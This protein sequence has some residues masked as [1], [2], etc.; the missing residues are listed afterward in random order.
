MQSHLI[1][2]TERGL[3]CSLS[4]LA[5][6]GT[7]GL[8]NAMNALRGIAVSAL[9]VATVL[10]ESELAERLDL[11]RLLTDSAAL[12][13]LVI[14]YQP[15]DNTVVFVYGT[16]RVV[17]QARPQVGSYE[18]VPTCTGR[19]GQDEVQGLV[20]A[21]ISR[22]FFD[23]PLRSYY[24]MTASDDGDDFWRALKLHSITIDDGQTRASRQF[25]DGIYQDKKQTIPADFAA[26]EEILIRMGKSATSGKPRHMA[27]GIS[28]PVRQNQSMS[29]PSPS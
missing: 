29:S 23:L 1:A 16:G 8:K 3:T 12:D 28:L 9:L 15:S 14:E 22:R 5:S 27:P 2:T 25:A 24:F 21:L 7:V 17:K 11:K 19:V 26:I 13:Q 10:G 20:Q 18:L 4:N 6:L